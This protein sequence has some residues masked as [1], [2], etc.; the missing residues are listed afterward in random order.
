M[1]PL[2]EMLYYQDANQFSKPWGS[3]D[4][5]AP[6]LLDLAHTM[7]NKKCS[8]PR[9]KIFGIFGLVD[10][11]SHLEDFKLD[12]GMAIAQVMG[13]ESGQAIKMDLFLVFVIPDYEN[14][15][16]QLGSWNLDEC[17]GK[18]PDFGAV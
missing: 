10:Y 11:L 13:N 15:R 4:R 12:Y 8:D 2:L 18:T 9:D 17:P 1:Q 16:L 3:G 6:D 7:R 5:A 14:T